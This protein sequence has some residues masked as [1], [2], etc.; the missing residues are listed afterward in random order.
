MR[1]ALLLGGAAAAGTCGILALRPQRSAG[2][3][4][5]DVGSLA[6][7]FPGTV[8]VFAATLDD[9]VPAVEIR[10]GEPFAAASVIKLGIMLAVYHAYDDGSASPADRVRLRAA[11]II[12][13]SPV[14]R[15]AHAGSGYTLD[16][17]VHA[18]IQ[19]SDN[20]AANALITA[21]G[22]AAINARMQAAEMSATRLARHF[23][24]DVP[25]GRRNLNVTTPRDVG[26][27]LLAIERATHEG[28]DTVASAASCR[29]MVHIL[30]GQEY[31]DM[32]PAGIARGVAVA[33][34]TGELDTVRNDAAIV[35]PYGESPYVLVVM[36]RDIE[37]DAQVRA[38]IAGIARRV[39]GALRAS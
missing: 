7:R 2:A 27:L 32:I 8:G 13:G 34:K 1:R 39:D 4:A 10:A 31:R 25:K 9:D 15:Y 30:V 19:A 20:T 17:L 21:F 22:F 18:M 33:N 11:D 29:E 14:L 37:G 5:V 26:R 23:A 28:I 16:R 6:Q 3:R 12:G 24:S 36:A 38:A 35:D